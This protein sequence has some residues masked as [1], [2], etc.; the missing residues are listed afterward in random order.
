MVHI[1]GDKVSSCFACLVVPCL[2]GVVIGGFLFI[3][4]GV[5]LSERVG[6]M[7]AATDFTSIAG[8]CTVSASAYERYTY[9]FSSPS[10]SSHVGPF[11]L[12]TSVPRVGRGTR[13]G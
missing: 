6:T 9:Y 8:G 1:N 10:C 5:D 4:G 7:N 3:S 13:V 11:L 2:A 12:G